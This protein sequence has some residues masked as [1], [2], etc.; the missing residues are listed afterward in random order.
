MVG[1]PSAAG[2]RPSYVI[3]GTMDFRGTSGDRALQALSTNA[4]SGKGPLTFER[5]TA[6]QAGTHYLLKFC[7]DDMSSDCLLFWLDVRAYTQLGAG[8]HREL[9]ARKIYAKYLE[10]GSPSQL[11]LPAALVSKAATGMASHAGPSSKIF[12]HVVAEVAYT[13]RF[14]VFPR[15]LTSAHYFKLVNLTLEERMKIELEFFDLYRLLGAG[16]FGMVLLV[17]RKT[18]GQHFACKVI[19]KRIVLS[20]NQVGSRSI[21]LQD[22]PNSVPP[23]RSRGV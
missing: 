10:A 2:R 1:G 19:D 22:L 16:G 21:P 4:L 23:G 8:I 13:L 12:D 6:S 15:F 17:R 9:A 11:A 5:V 18:S 14:D 7:V 20:Q 3:A